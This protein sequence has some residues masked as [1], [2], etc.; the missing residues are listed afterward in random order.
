MSRAISGKA[1]RVL[2]A[3]WTAGGRLRDW[4]MLLK[5]L[6]A[7]GGREALAFQYI[8]GS[9]I[10]IGA[11]HRPMR[12]PANANVNYVDRLPVS[13]LR[14]QYPELNGCALV[15]VDVVSDG[16]K[17][18]EFEA[19]SQD[20]VIANHFLEHCENPIGAVESFLRVLKPKGIVYLA[21]PDKRYTF[22]AGR[23]ITGLQHLVRDYREGPG[24]SREE[25]FREWR[26]LVEQEFRNDPQ[27]SMETLMGP[28]Y[29]I[30]FHVWTFVEILEFIVH[31]KKE[32][33]FDFEPEQLISGK[34]E[35]V[36]ILRKA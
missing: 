7:P 24:G 13:E 5:L 21:V 14:R 26:A 35:I 22:D 9:G 27:R 17:L 10:E 6:T 11:L 3:V 18:A 29:S 36:A 30:H 19:G 2:Q 16:E 25:H 12:V 31:L 20:F 1:A 28:S 32:L 34:S 8:R 23:A 4:R 33:E 15:E